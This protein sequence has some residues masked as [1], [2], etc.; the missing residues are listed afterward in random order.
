MKL[1]KFRALKQKID[2]ERLV[3]ILESGK[4]WCSKFYTMNDPME[5]IYLSN[6]TEDDVAK[7]FSEKNNYL[8]CSFAG[9]KGLLEPL[10]WG[11]YANGFKGVVIEV[12][13]DESQIKKFKQITYRPKIPMTKNVLT[14]LTTKLCSWCHED[15]WRYLCQDSFG[16]KGKNIQIG[17]ITGIY[18]GRPYKDATNSEQI[19]SSYDPL[20]NYYEWQNELK[21]IA[22]EKNIFV[23]EVK[24]SSNKVRIKN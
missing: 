23:K 9:E 11:Y 17:K 1:Y 7:I 12:E 24:I 3:D 19:I 4:F 15:E 21:S 2:F 13:I 22:N 10:M 20:K 8:I 5:G 16:E 6:G 14:I 18:L